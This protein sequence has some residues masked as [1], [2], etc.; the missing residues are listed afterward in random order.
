[1]H[2]YGTLL[3][4]Y[5]H[6]RDRTEARWISDPPTPES[7]FAEADQLERRWLADVAAAR[8]GDGRPSWVRRSWKA[9]DRAAHIDKEL[10]S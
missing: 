1:M 4:R 3:A 9:V 10:A 2:A 7:A 8:L 5:R 6:A